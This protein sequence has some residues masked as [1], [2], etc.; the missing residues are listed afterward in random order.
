LGVLL[1]LADKA[2]CEITT[3][4]YQFFFYQFVV[5]LL[6]LGLI[7]EIQISLMFLATYMHIVIDL[8]FDLCGTFQFFILFK[9]EK[10]KI[11]FL[12]IFLFVAVGF[13]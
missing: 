8:C 5:K 10:K 4:F 3:E 13:L 7:L 6:S 2:H 1:F 11:K 12:L 9:L